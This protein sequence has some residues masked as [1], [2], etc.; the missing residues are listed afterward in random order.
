MHS[1]HI[2]SARFATSIGSSPHSPGLSA[3]AFTHAGQQHAELS[4]TIPQA[5]TTESEMESA[6]DREYMEV[7]D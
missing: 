6:V 7:K 4:A 2:A 1:F 3:P 5:N